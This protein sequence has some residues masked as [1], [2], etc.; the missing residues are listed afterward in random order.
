MEIKEY[1]NK[2]LPNL[3][4]NILPQIF[5]EN[6]VELTEE[7]E[8]YLRETPK[9]TNNAILKELLNS[10]SQSGLVFEFDGDFIYQSGKLLAT[11][12]DR[13]DI[14]P[15]L[16]KIKNGDKSMIT[17]GDHTVSGKVTIQDYHGAPSF[18]CFDLDDNFIKGWDGMFRLNGEEIVSSEISVV[19]HGETETTGHVKIEIID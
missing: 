3:N 10:T 19:L 5:E 18:Y 17:V 11:V 6:G 13:E 14:Y 16:S 2:N 15:F 4:W 12:Y 7:I 1:I 9:N 8:R